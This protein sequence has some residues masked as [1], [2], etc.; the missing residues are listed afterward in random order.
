MGL[1]LPSPPPH[2]MGGTSARG[3]SIDRGIYE[4]DIDLMRGGNLTLIDYIIN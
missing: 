2:H 4:G 1:H 3:Q